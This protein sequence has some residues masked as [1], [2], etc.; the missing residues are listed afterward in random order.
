MAADVVNPNVQLERSERSGVD[1]AAL[2]KPIIDS[3]VMS[4]YS[5]FDDKEDMIVTAYV[6]NQLP[7]RRA[8]QDMDHYKKLRD[9]FVQD[10]IQCMATNR[11]K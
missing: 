3:G 2:N 4:V 1:I 8:F 5:L 7:E 10:Y 6:L 11:R 9:T